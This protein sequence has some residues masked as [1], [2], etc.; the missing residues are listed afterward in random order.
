[1]FRC[2]YQ[3]MLK[4]CLLILSI[5]I[6]LPVFAGEFEEAM[7]K[8]A[9]IFLYIYTPDCT[10]CNDFLPTYNK[11]AKTYE[12]SYKFVKA[13]ASTKYGKKLLLQFGGRYVPFV[14]LLNGQKRQMLNIHPDCLYDNACVEKKVKEF[15]GFKV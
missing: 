10:Y 2:Y 6:S 15:K 11:L 12:N 3:I 8:G 1:M 14:V 7:A 9:D 13:D 4:K 5:L